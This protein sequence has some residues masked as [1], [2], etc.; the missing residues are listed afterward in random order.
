MHVFQ[1]LEYLPT[2]GRHGRQDTL[3]LLEGIQNSRVKLVEIIGQMHARM[4]ANGLAL[5]TMG[6][7]TQCTV[8][9]NNQALA[10]ILQYVV[11]VTTRTERMTSEILTRLA[12][13]QGQSH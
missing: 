12:S 3:N 4:E 1:P 11:D 10:N 6:T 13:S 5:A 9:D 8:A 2:A 7:D